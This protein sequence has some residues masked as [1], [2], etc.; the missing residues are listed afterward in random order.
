MG[1]RPVSFN[2]V[3]SGVSGLQEHVWLK[4][5]F[6]GWDSFL[7]PVFLREVAQFIRVLPS[8]FPIS[9]LVGF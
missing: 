3:L 5:M 4:S 6:L 7:Y 9:L 2:G 1:L 8:K